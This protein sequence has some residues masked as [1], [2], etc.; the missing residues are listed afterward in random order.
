VKGV[1]GKS[2][3][4][5]SVSTQAKIAQSVEHSTEN[6]GVGGS[7]PPLGISFKAARKA[8]LLLTI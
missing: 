5:Y 3:P 4:C 6:A 1:D 7:I 2:F 8:A